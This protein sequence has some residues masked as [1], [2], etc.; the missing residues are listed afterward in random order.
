METTISAEIQSDPTLAP[1]FRAAN[2]MLRD[3]VGR[4]RN[5]PR[6][7]WRLV[8]KDNPSWL[9]ELE[10]FD[11]PESFAR[12]FTVEELA[13]AWALRFKLTGL[14]G[15]LIM[16]AYQASSGRLLEALRELREDE[17]TRESVLQST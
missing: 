15:D 2:E 13:D 7:V 6:G 1:V 3:T 10:L 5:P 16:K 4:A 11:P 14:W 12:Q 9:V 8:R 17:Q